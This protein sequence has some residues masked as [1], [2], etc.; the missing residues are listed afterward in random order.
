MKLKRGYGEPEVGSSGIVMVP[1]SIHCGTTKYADSSRSSCWS[2]LRQH[3]LRLRFDT[4]FDYYPRFLDPF[5]F[6]DCGKV[7]R[8]LL[9]VRSSLPN[10]KMR[11]WTE[12]CVSG[13]NWGRTK[14]LMLKPWT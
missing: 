8:P 3:E 7:V 11:A 2:L 10:I 9:A 4:A 1:I 13:K 12:T 5:S 6:P 14:H